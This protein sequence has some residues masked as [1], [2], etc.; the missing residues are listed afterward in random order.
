MKYTEYLLNIVIIILF[1]TPII[2]LYFNFKHSFHDG[3]V[4][5]IVF[6][7]ITLAVVLKSKY[8]KK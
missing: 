3:I 1:V 4:T 8:F 6:G 7:F 2:A 5:L